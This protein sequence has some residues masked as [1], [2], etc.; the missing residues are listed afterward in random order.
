MGP[1]P[2]NA[3]PRVL[4]AQAL[5]L[6][7][8]M[9]PPFFSIMD[10]IRGGLQYVFQTSSPYTALISGTGHA[11]ME[12][13]VINLCERGELLLVVRHGVWGTRAAE[14]ARRQGVRVEFVEVEPGCVVPIETL[15]AKLRELRPKM[16][17]T[18]QGD[19]ST[20][21]LQPLEGLAET[22][23]ETGTLLAVDTVCSLGGV[24]FFF[25][26]WGIDLV[27]SGAQKCL[28]APPGSAP[29][30]LSRRAVDAVAARKTPC[31]SYYLD[32]SQIGAYWGWFLPETPRPYHHTGM[33]STWYGVREALAVVAEQ[34]L[35]AMWARHKAVDDELWAGL[36]ELG[37]ERFVAD[38]DAFLL[39]VNTIVVP[40][41]VDAAKL[42][43]HAMQRFSVEIS[44][45][46]GP[47]AGKV[48]RVGIMGYN[49]QPI[50]VRMVLAAFK[51]GLE[52]QGWKKQ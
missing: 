4:Q 50:N 45:G 49:A 26:R 27:Y 31:P 7:G 8:H 38:D 33:V 29:I 30:A 10:E 1:G 17:F 20:G 34:G 9:H 21:V 28:A 16:L 32:L 3:N 12:A 35:P 47:L 36:E 23:R 14:M 22:A 19:S 37:L 39:T 13:S 51:E 5:P 18:V 48:W 11:A 40:E 25:D 44:G 41:G 52:A 42:S 24:P 15:K 6:L 46:L 2:G 43:A